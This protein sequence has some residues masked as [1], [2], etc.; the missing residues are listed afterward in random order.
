MTE[1]I[2]SVDGDYAAALERNVNTLAAHAP[3]IGDNS[4][5]VPLAELLAEELASGKARA[6]ELVA[7]AAEA[8]IASDQD[9][10]KVT[11][12]VALI[13]SHHKFLDGE[14]EARKRPFLEGV[15]TVDAAYGAVIQPLV[16]ARGGN[17]GRGGL[18]AMLTQ[19]Q[20]K[21]EAEAR[22][23]RERI[24]AKQRAREEE[25]ERAREAAKAAGRGTLAAELAHLRAKEEADR[26]GRQAETIRPEPIRS[27]A[28]AVSMRREIA[29][30]IVDEKKAI[31][32]LYKNRRGELL[33]YGRTI[34]GAHLR[35]MGVDAA[36]SAAIPGVEVTIESRAQVR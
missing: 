23:E 24:E 33:N 32:W 4:G 10:E 1:Y 15:R 16:F 27:A 12:L 31:A 17:N 8:L 20:Q 22:V 3:G 29:F 34:L 19:W 28:G 26:L 21:R 25:A 2:S 14:R 35:S 9:A 18:G 13:R 5:A 11:A 30:K 6:D 7:A 36:Q